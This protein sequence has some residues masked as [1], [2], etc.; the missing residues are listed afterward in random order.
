MK[1]KKIKKYV[2]WLTFADGAVKKVITESMSE[3]WKRGKT[4]GNC[5]SVAGSKSCAEVYRKTAAAADP[6]RLI[7][8]L[9]YLSDPY[10][11]DPHAGD[12]SGSLIYHMQEAAK[13]A[14]VI[15]ENF[16]RVVVEE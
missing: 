5:V 3:A 9:R 16:P 7:E 12:D 11:H 8:L 13:E 14:L 4:M 15:V 1:K 10:I 2:W 6:E